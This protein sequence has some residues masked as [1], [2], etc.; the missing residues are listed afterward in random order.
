[1]PLHIFQ[2]EKRKKRLFFRFWTGTRGKTHL[3]F[4]TFK[5]FFNRHGETFLRKNA[6][7]FLI[8]GENVV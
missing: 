5:P 7:R 3:G 6:K 8:S 1:M 4:P 2:E